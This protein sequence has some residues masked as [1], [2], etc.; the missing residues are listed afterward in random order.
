MDKRILVHYALYSFKDRFWD[1]PG[2]ERTDILLQFFKAIENASQKTWFYQVYPAQ[3]K[4]DIL[5]WST[6]EA[7]DLNAPLEFFDKYA[8]EASSFRS[9]LNP[10]L[11]LWGVTKPSIYSKAK[12]SAQEL[13]PFES[14]RK[15][16]FIVYPFTKT[17]SWY[18]K[19]REARQEMM[20]GH[21][22]IGKSY[23]EITQLLLYSF[24]LQDQEFIVSYETEN[25]PSFSDLVYELRST[26]ARVYTLSDVP[27][28]T[29]VYRQ[30]DELAAIFSGKQIPE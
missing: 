17:A 11:T 29:A 21:I 5:V 10:A 2:K 19:D 8:R 22:R 30:A 24:G 14:N 12:R 4:F 15:P 25:L 20:N 1:L 18:M 6:I 7:D 26:E 28:I 16:Y 23:P 3:T 13:D 27:I 9:Y